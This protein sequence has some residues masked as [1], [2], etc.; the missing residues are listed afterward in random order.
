MEESYLTVDVVDHV[1]KTALKK[2]GSESG[3]VLS[4]ASNRAATAANTEIK[5]RTAE[6]FIVRQRDIQ[7]ALWTRKATVA[8]PQAQLRYKSK[9]K[10][11][12]EWR[13]GGSGAVTPQR[14]VSHTGRRP[15][16]NVYKAGI[17][18]GEGKKPYGR[19]P[20]AFVQ[21]MPRNGGIIF[22]RREHNFSRSK[23][24]AIQAPALTQVMAARKI[25]EP[26][27]GRAN[28]IFCKR[29]DAELDYLL[30]S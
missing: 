1:L 28:E 6:L 3:V 10:N 14:I 24:K 5:K 21:R 12:Y 25:M 26:A 11:L 22:V 30:K 17:K 18:R 16:P 13:A 2:M 15:N 19:A 29:L 4:R 9:K 23:L 7:E 20:K 8:R 27:T